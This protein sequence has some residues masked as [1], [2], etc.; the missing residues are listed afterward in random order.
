METFNIT[1]VSIVSLNAYL[2]LRLRYFW[3]FFVK[4]LLR[5]IQTFEHKVLLVQ[6]NGSSMI[7]DPSPVE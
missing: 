6:I 4:F 3:I 2:S 1:K 5:P 7:S